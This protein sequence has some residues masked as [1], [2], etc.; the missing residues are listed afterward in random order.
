MEIK[1]STKEEFDVMKKSMGNTIT[2]SYDDFTSEVKQL[3]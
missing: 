3:C 2:S 1:S